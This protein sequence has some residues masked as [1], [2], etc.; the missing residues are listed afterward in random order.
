MYPM[1][2]QQKANKHI[3]RNLYKFNE[4]TWDRLLSN[5]ELADYCET[6][7]HSKNKL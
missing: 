3:S 1:L 7:I 4:V 5:K 2:E 6:V